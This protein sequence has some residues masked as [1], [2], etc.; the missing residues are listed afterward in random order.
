MYDY[1]SDEEINDDMLD[2]EK[3]ITDA[4]YDYDLDELAVD[5]HPKQQC[6]E[7][8]VHQRRRKYTNSNCEEEQHVDESVNQPNLPTQQSRKRR[9]RIK[10]SD[11]D[12]DDNGETDAVNDRDG[13]GN[14]DV[15]EN[16]NDAE[17]EDSNAGNNGVDDVYSNTDG[18]NG[19]S[20]E[21]TCSSHF[22]IPTISSYTCQ[23][24]NDISC[25]SDSS[26]PSAIHLPAMHLQYACENTKHCTKTA[27]QFQTHYDILPPTVTLDAQYLDHHQHPI[28]TDFFRTHSIVAIRSEMGTGKTEAILWQLVLQYFHSSSP[29]QQQ[30][31]SSRPVR[32]LWLSIKRV[33]SNSLAQRIQRFQQHIQTNY[34]QYNDIIMSFINYLDIKNNAAD[35]EQLRNCARVI[36]SIESLYRLTLHETTLKPYDLVILDEVEELMMNMHATTMSR[37]RRAAYDTIQVILGS[38]T[39]VW[40]ADAQLSQDTG[41]WFLQTLCKKAASISMGTLVNTYRTLRRDVIEYSKEDHCCEVLK[42][43][44]MTGKNVIVCS[45]SKTQAK[46]LHQMLVDVIQIYFDDDKQVKPTLK[47]MTGDNCKSE[48]DEFISNLTSW[49]VNVLIVSPFLTAGVDYSMV[50]NRN[51]KTF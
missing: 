27:L 22:N 7:L 17:D 8:P 40:T 4:N 3:N 5:D 50:S 24:N 49:N 47:L 43:Y 12:D 36:V 20:Y 33:Y 18:N 32:I 15:V 39:R 30:Y 35:N 26:L 9:K 29:W 6:I 23:C 21:P 31:G 25:N 2:L 16:S 48:K 41:L 13:N 42:H 1:P 14:N 45:N 28:I 34:P 37:H 44:M 19:A 46:K 11:D 10:I 38:A 51:L